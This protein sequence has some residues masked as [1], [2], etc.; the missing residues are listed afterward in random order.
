[1]LWLSKLLD[2]DEMMYSSNE[3]RETIAAMR[4]RH[5]MMQTLDGAELGQAQNI[6]M[7]LAELPGIIAQQLQQ[8][9]ALEI[10]DGQMSEQRQI[11]DQ[12]TA[13]ERAVTEQSEEMKHKRTMEINAQNQQG[14]VQLEAM[15][16]LGAMNQPK[17]AAA[18]K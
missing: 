13:E 7:I 15:R 12:K 1:M 3:L 9:Q 2:T 14:N 16:Q 6:E 8:A 5:I 4:T 17:P 10:Q 18:A 11:E